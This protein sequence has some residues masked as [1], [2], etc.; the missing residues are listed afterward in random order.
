[1]LRGLLKGAQSIKVLLQSKLWMIAPVSKRKNSRGELKGGGERE[2]LGRF[3]LAGRRNL[4][5][6]DATSLHVSFPD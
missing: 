5:N 6:A 2:I 3:P 1:L 4:R